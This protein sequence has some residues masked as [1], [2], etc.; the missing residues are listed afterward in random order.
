VTAAAVA[1]FA[2]RGRAI[3]GA[4]VAAVRL[5]TRAPALS[6][7]CAAD[8][9][10]EIQERFA[11]AALGVGSHRPADEDQ[12]DAAKKAD[13]TAQLARLRQER[14]VTPAKTGVRQG[15]AAREAAATAVRAPGRRS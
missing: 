15:A 12:K 8:R 5:A 3:G 13:G 11:S 4:M 10:P 9:V 7:V 1:S 2:A 14:R 6:C